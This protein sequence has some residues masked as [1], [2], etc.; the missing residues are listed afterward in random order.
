MS[1]EN[2]AQ[3]EKFRLHSPLAKEIL[4][5]RKAGGYAC[6]LHTSAFPLSFLPFQTDR[7]ALHW[8]AGA[9]NV[10]AVRLLLDHDVPVDDEDSVRRQISLLCPANVFCVGGALGTECWDSGDRRHLS[11]GWVAQGFAGC[12][13][14][15]EAGAVPFW[16]KPC[17]QMCLCS[18]FSPFPCMHSD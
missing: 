5:F 7:T 1:K 18:V 2:L 4:A 11:P 14:P 17:F 3:C 15:A 10:D 12:G 8:A 16:S 13:L 9:G 6:P